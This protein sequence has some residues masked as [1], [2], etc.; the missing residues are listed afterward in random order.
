MR[1]CGECNVC[2]VVPEMTV[3]D[4]GFSKKSF[5][6]CPKL[7]GIISDKQCTIYKDRPTKCSQFTC[8][9]I[10]GFGNEND[11]PDKNNLL[12]F[13]NRINNGNWI[14]AIETKEDSILKNK[15]ILIEVSKKS[16][17]AIIIQ[18]F[19]SKKIAG[20][21]TVLKNSLVSK[22]KQM[23]G[24]FLRWIDEDKE[25]GLYKLYNPAEK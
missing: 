14:F 10:K 5:V 2:C 8:L 16:D 9:W 13:K 25:I 6:R 23:M 22:A 19:N 3:A 20:D 4:H 15:E 18:K 1:N 11:R 24:E 12:L 17:T 7:S 21:E